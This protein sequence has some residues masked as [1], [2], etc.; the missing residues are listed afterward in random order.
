MLGR[1]Q[2]QGTTGV[3]RLRVGRWRLYRAI[4]QGNSALAFTSNDTVVLTLGVFRAG[5]FD[6]GA[7]YRH[8]AGCRA[9]SNEKYSLPIR[10]VLCHCRFLGGRPLHW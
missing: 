10:I 4:N 2:G 3:T 6:R 8:K 1:L 5:G 7:R 9:L